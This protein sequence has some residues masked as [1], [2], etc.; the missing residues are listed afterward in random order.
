MPRVV[1]KLNVSSTDVSMLAIILLL[2][3]KQIWIQKFLSAKITEN[4]NIQHLCVMPRAWDM[5][6]VIDPT[7][8]SIINILLS[9]I[10]PTLRLILLD[11]KQNKTSC[12]FIVSG[13]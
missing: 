4:G 13:T 11:W 10:K 8:L 6:S 3:K 7:K 9:A 1:Q 5:S 2:F 12:V